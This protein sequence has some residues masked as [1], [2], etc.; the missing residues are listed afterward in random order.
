MDSANVCE[1]S[2]CSGN[3]IVNIGLLG[4]G[5]PSVC[6]EDFVVQSTQLQF[7]EHTVSIHWNLFLA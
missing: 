5:Y 2:I 1:I 4:T 6:Q 7:R 3:F